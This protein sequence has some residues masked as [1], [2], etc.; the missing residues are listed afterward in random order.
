MRGRDTPDGIAHIVG[1][2]QR[3][4]AR[5]LDTDR[6]AERLIVAD[7]AGEDVDRHSV[8]LCAAEGHENHLVT[9]L[10]DAVPR[11]VFAEECPLCKAW[12][13]LL[14]GAECKSQRGDV[15]AKREFRGDGAG[16]E[17][18]TGRLHPDVHMLSIIAVRPTVKG[19]FA[20]RG[21]IIGD[22][23]A[24]ELVTFV[25]G[26]PQRAAPRVEGNADR[27]AQASGKDV[28]SA[29]PRIDLPNC[30]AALLDRHAIF[31]DIAV[32]S[33]A[34]VQETAVWRDDQ[35]LGPVM[36]AA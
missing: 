23:V 14:A 18:G 11:T 33:D 35:R 4:I 10:R 8:R 21:D 5:N 3:A 16:D 13:E 24:A 22:E 36:I 27:I 12:P 32:R 6:T 2:Q 31:A 34:D 20:D 19:P 17:V 15:R 30:S 25:D 29:S 26:R 9:A 7:K 28:R 1:D